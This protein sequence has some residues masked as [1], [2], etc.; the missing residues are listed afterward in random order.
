MGARRPVAAPVPVPSVRARPVPVPPV[1]VP[2]SSI[3]T[4]PRSSSPQADTPAAA[5]IPIVTLAARAAP[6]LTVVF[7][8]GDLGYPNYGRGR[9]RRTSTATAPFE[10]REAPSNQDRRLPMGVG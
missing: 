10:D 7:L 8:T 3:R 5:P 4:P 9:H 2:P 1:P 6:L